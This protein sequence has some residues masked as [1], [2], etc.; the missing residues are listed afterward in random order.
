MRA[1]DFCESQATEVGGRSW[2]GIVGLAA[3]PIVVALAF[4]YLPAGPESV[5]WQLR[6][7]QVF[8]E[9]QMA[10][11]ADLGGRVWKIPDDPLLGWPYQS[12]I[13]KYPHLLEGFDLLLIS[14]ISAHLLDPATNYHFLV[15]SVIAI[16][17]WIAGWLTFRLTRSYLWAAASILL[18]TLNEQ[19]AGRMNA[20]LHLFKFGW[21]LLAT[22][23]FWRFLEG[24]PGGGGLRWGWGSRWFFRGRSTSDTSW[25]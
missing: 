25:P 14:T 8:Y 12:E 11:A 16:N 5:A 2:P 18:I 17:G 15:M 21:F 22:W 6:G 4:Y 23:T 20:H 7:D 10:R 13:A 19:V 3:L 24:L 9:Y 1:N